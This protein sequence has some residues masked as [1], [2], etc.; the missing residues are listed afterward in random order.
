M[1]SGVYWTATEEHH[2]AREAA[3]ASMNAVVRGAKQEWVALFAS[4]AVV[5]DPVGPSP[6][7]PKGDGHHGKAGITAFWENTIAQAA[8][9]EFHI[10]DSF[11][12]GH[13]VANTGFIR[14]FMPDGSQMDAEG[15]FVYRV[16]TTGMIRSMRAFWEFDRALTTLR[17]ADS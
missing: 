9:L 8:R 5:E 16:D 3:M 7:D 13:E 1:D 14:T 12:T 2:P 4:D 6:L 10:H 11:A 17:Q 15:V